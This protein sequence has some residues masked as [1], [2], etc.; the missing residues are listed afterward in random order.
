M[1][2][3]PTSATTK[4]SRLTYLNGYPGD[5]VDTYFK[6][7]G[8]GG[9]VAG[10]VSLGVEGLDQGARRLTG[11]EYEKPKGIM[12][13]T[14]RDVSDVFEHIKEGEVIQAASAGWSVVSGDIL[15][16]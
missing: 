11:R 1:R 14:R 16:D 2:F 10:L 7:T 6:G 5:V 9:K 3:A 12:G 8:I 13:R 15:M 4:E